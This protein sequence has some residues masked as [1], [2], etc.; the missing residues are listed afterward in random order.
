MPVAI[1]FS[2]PVNSTAQFFDGAVKGDAA[3]SAASLTADANNSAASLIPKDNRSTDEDFDDVLALLLNGGIPPLQPLP[4]QLYVEAKTTEA[5]TADA[6][7]AFSGGDSNAAGNSNFVSVGQLLLQ[8]RDFAPPRTTASLGLAKATTTLSENVAISDTSES[9]NT[10]ELRPSNTAA[11][12]IATSA[13]VASNMT[14]TVASPAIDSKVNFD[15]ALTATTQTGQSVASSQITDGDEIL[16]T[17]VLPISGAA[18][19]VDTPTT[20]IDVSI[21][22]NSV[23]SVT[24]KPLSKD[25]IQALERIG[26][27]PESEVVSDQESQPTMLETKSQTPTLPDSGL[28]GA[29]DPVAAKLP[30][31]LKTF[32]DAQAAAVKT[33]ASV[34]PIA[35]ALNGTPPPDQ[36]HA[37]LSASDARVASSANT[38][39]QSAETLLRSAPAKL[40]EA[41]TGLSVSI[42][43]SQSVP[44]RTDSTPDPMFA[45]SEQPQAAVVSAK[46][47][48]FS[49][50]DSLASDRSV[51]QISSTSDSTAS[52]MQNGLI[53]SASPNSVPDLAASISAEIRQ[54]LTSQVSQAIM[55]HVERNGVRQN[56]SLSVRL[57]PPE[58]GEMTIQLSKTHEGLAVRVTAREAVTMDML[59]AR[60]QEIEVRSCVVSTSI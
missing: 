17:Q 12:T 46:R 34:T 52:A 29:V 22:A 6:P 42:E 43:S 27:P 41:G 16:S 39:S 28:S 2:D 31:P 53:S 57:D 11:T 36:Q 59:F 58:L 55:D 21:L 14:G 60:G 10:V 38:L 9:A 5:G 56:E 7:S 24:A 48:A 23:E 37:L 15:K 51:S 40:A 32:A 25:I 54:P 33:T 47:R 18:A 45:V 8:G 4:V 3:S 30:L 49:D 13:R 26:R 44:G 50:A 1:S 19:N 20:T 35:N